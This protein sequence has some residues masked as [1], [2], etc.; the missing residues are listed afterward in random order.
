MDFTEQ[1]SSSAADSIVINR[2]VVGMRV[3]GLQKVRRVKYALG[4][5]LVPPRLS[6]TFAVYSDERWEKSVRLGSDGGPIFCRKNLRPT[7]RGKKRPNGTPLRERCGP[8]VGKRPRIV[9]GS[10]RSFDGPQPGDQG[11]PPRGDCHDFAGSPVDPEV[12]EGGDITY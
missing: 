12:R 8:T 2:S 6:A 10:E 11:R 7:N 3:S 1:S 4:C 9:I 5:T